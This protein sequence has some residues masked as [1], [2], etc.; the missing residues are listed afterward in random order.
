MN[1]NKM[2]NVRNLIGYN[3]VFGI[4]YMYVLLY[5]EY[6]LGCGIFFFYE[7]KIILK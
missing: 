4:Y 3:I 6:L 2:Y 1:V 5:L 7:I